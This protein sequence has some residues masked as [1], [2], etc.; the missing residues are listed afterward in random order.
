LNQAFNFWYQSAKEQAV[1]SQI[2]LFELDWLILGF[3]AEDKLKL[4]LGLIQ[5]EPEQLRQ[6]QLLWQSRLSDRLPV[7][8]LLGKTSWRDLELFV[9]PAVL[10]PRPETEL[11]IDIVLE[12]RQNLDL[13]TDSEVWLDLGTGSGAIAISLAKLL[14]LIEIHAVDL[15]EKALAIAIKNANH[16]QIAHRIDWHQ[17]DWFEPLANLDLN[18]K[19]SGMVSN[20]PYIPTELILQLQPEVS[21]HEP[22]L[23]LDGGLNGLKAIAQL[24][25]QAQNYLQPGGF[26]ITEIM[27]GQQ[28]QVKTILEKLGSYSQIQ[29]HHDQSGWIRFVSCILEQP[30]IDTPFPL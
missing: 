2:A 18:H 17:G 26:W 21:K 29:F 8:Y 10:I 20:P 9:S 11:I 28:D 23:A 14:P 13:K 27:A 3:L 1:E 30:E 19:V 25:E 4:R 15:S 22:H 6:L 24:A 5:P 12:A 16:H 7:Q